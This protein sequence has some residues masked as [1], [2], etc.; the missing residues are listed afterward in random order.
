MDKILE[1]KKGKKLKKGI[2]IS[3]IALFII[4]ITVVNLTRKKQVNLDRITLGI[5]KV[6]QGDF[7]DVIVF[8][9]TVHPK[10]SIFINVIQGGAIAEVYAESGQ[11]V[12]KGT[13][14]LR[15]HNPNAEL[16]Y[17]TQETNIVEQI[18]SLRNIRATIKT[19]QLD[20]QQQ[21]LNIDNDF[22]NAERQYK[23]D[24]TLYKKHVIARNA[25]EASV[26]EFNY[27]KGRNK[28]IKANVNQEKLDRQIQLARINTSLHNMEKSLELLKKNKENFIIKAPSDGLLSSFNPVLG[29]HYNQGQ[30]IGKIDVLDGYKLEAKMDEYYIAKLHEGIQGNA[31]TTEA[32]YPVETSKIHPEIVNGQFTLELLFKN[33]SVSSNLKRG[34]TLKTKVFLSNN[35]KALLVPKGLFYQSTQGKWVY[36]MDGND[37]AIKRN[38]KI[39][40]ENPFYYEVLE[41]LSEGDQI[42]TSSYDDFIDVEQINIK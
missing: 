27:Q 39:G 23:I 4:A 26:Q 28:V 3:L 25:Y 36:V 20:L 32:T 1:P 6:T 40:R 19:Q 34:M 41:G 5:K 14:L 8:N 13:P 24:T 42:L 17:L 11:R 12:S 10:T 31:I 18:N 30:S 9:S 7:E 37:K 21:L 38:I 2:W 16:S 15:I 22:K 33:D 35:S 29:E